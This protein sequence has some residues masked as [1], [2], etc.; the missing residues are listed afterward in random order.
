MFPFFSGRITELSTLKHWI[1]EENCR[2]IAISGMV[3]IGKTAL[4]V[5]LT[6]EIKQQ[7]E[8]V[9]YYNINTG[10]SLSELLTE[11][12]DYCLISPPPEFI[13]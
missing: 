2:L 1:L 11:I 4:S 5:K 6:Q 9:F 12:C 8:F 10:L 7:F 3:G 13:K